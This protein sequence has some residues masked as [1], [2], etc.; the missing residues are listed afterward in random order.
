[1]RPGRMAARRIS[2]ELTA[3]HF[4]ESN[5]TTLTELLLGAFLLAFELVR[6]QLFKIVKHALHGLVHL[7]SLADSFAGVSGVKLSQL[8]QY[9]VAF[10]VQE[11]LPSLH[12]VI[13]A[14][15]VSVPPEPSGSQPGPQRRAHR[16]N[17]DR[18]FQAPRRCSCN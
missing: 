18:T 15:P 10:F 7:Q 16:A 5:N 13:I 1:M 2:W 4:L 8:F 9:P 14:P 11:D 17:A 6:M 12:T 3:L